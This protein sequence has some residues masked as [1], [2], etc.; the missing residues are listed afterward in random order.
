MTISLLQDRTLSKDLVVK[1]IRR[2]QGL[3]VKEDVWHFG[4]SESSKKL[5]GFMAPSWFTVSGVTVWNWPD[6]SVQ[7]VRIATRISRVAVHPDGILIAYSNKQ[8]IA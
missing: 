2:T 6:L 3:P 1:K 7:N 4:F 5:F 8:D